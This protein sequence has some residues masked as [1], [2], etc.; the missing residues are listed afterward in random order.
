[1]MCQGI[2]RHPTVWEWIA[3]FVLAGH[4]QALCREQ[5]ALRHNKRIYSLANDDPDMSGL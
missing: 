2:V 4:R 5:Q 3:V 1:M